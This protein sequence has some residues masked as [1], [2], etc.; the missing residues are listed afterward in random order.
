MV[1][2]LIS[3]NFVKL[4]TIVTDARPQ[5]RFVHSCGQSESFAQADVIFAILDIATEFD[6]IENMFIES[7]R[8]LH[9]SN[10]AVH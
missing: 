4:Q 6:I 1:N 3:M 7:R 5:L 2:A 10:V 8:V 9:N